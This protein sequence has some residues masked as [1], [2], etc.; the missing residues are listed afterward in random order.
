V[1]W[2]GLNK[3]DSSGAVAIEFAIVGLVFISMMLLTM[4]TGWQLLIDWALDAGARAASRFGTT[5]TVVAA[6]VQPPPTSRGDSIQAIVI[7]ASG[8][9]LQPGRLQIADAAYA[10]FAGVGTGAS[11]AGAGTAGQVVRYTFTYTQ[12]YLTPIAAA[13][14]GQQNMIHTAQVTVL[15]EPFPSN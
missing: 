10:N 8:G 5:G 4:E 6:G 15:N 13:I 2:P 7:Q 3:R 9:L 1:K 14:T 11:T 12:P